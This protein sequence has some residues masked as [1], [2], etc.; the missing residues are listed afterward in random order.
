MRAT[1]CVIALKH[2]TFFL[3]QELHLLEK[4]KVKLLSLLTQG[5]FRAT[6]VQVKKLQPCVQ[7]HSNFDRCLRSWSCCA[8]DGD[9]EDVW[10]IRPL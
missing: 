7:D 10:R 5:G 9:A 3:E 4:L 8:G 1:E 2:I 6:G